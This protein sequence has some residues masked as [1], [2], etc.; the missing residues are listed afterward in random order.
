MGW[1]QDVADYIAKGNLEAFIEEFF[2]GSSPSSFGTGIRLN[3]SPC[4]GHNDCF[5]FSRIKNVGTCYSCGTS[6]SKI[7]FVETVMGKDQARA[8]IEKWSGIRYIH[9][10]FTEDET[11][12]YNTKKRVQELAH[13]AVAHYHQRLMNDAPALEKQTGL[14]RESKQRAH[15]TTALKEFKVGLSGGY[16]E[17]HAKM[18][19]EGYTLAELKE[20]GKLIW[21]PE[22]NFIYP[23]YDLRGNVIR[24]NTK[25]FFR[26]C[27][28]K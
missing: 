28:H 1:R 24:I 22:G 27:Q 15:S 10:N 5:S 21:V 12:A 19:E 14:N 13:K 4:C 2:P 7:S 23:Y 11:A 25:M 8:A 17:F 9:Q 26:T 18:R 3:P 16:L 6:G 20:A